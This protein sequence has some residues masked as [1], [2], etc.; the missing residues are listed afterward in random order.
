MPPETLLFEIGLFAE[1]RHTTDLFRDQ[2]AAIQFE[3]T[4]D[5]FK[6]F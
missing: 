3:A 6:Q 1:H 5:P 2:I 4:I